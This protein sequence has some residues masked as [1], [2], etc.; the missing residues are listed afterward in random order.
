MIHQETFTENEYENS[1]KNSI[2]KT[3]F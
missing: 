2:D 3:L 1:N